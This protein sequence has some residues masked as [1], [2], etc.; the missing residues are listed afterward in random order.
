LQGNKNIEKLEKEINALINV[1]DELNCNEIEKALDKLKNDI[2]N[3]NYEEE[4]YEEEIEKLRNEQR[5]YFT[6]KD[7]DK[8]I[9]L[10]KELEYIKFG[11]ELEEL[12]SQNY[13]GLKLFQDRLFIEKN[14]SDYIAINS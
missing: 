12:I 11:E 10:E 2:S 7:E 5:K 3:S 1:T 8:Y 6:I 4:N 13:S 14:N 9:K